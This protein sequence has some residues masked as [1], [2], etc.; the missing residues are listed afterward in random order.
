MQKPK[1]SIICDLAN[2]GT[3]HQICRWI[4]LSLIV[5]SVMLLI[6]EINDMNIALH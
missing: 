3:V 6:S 5:T 1:H 4:L 2:S